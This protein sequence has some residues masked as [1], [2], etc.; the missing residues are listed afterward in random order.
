VFDAVA[1]GFR[2]NAAVAPRTIY[3]ADANDLNQPKQLLSGITDVA[4]TGASWVPDHPWV[5]FPMQPANGPLGLWLVDVSDGRKVLLRAGAGFGRA[6][7]N[8]TGVVALPEDADAPIGTTRRARM[9][10]FHLNYASI[11]AVLKRG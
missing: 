5:L 2:G 4:G 6:D 1:T 10:L 9:D 8:S 11:K 7:V 3:V